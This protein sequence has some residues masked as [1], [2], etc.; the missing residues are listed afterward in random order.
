MSKIASWLVV[1][2]L[3]V[4]TAAKVLSYMGQASGIGVEGNTANAGL[5]P[6]Y[7]L[8][9]M[10]LISFALIAVDVSVLKGVDYASSK[11]LARYAGGQLV[12]KVV[13]FILLVGLLTLVLVDLAINVAVWGATL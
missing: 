13:V 12:V 2:V 5:I 7:G 6:G 4:S 11:F 1:T 3:L 9:G 8:L 10:H